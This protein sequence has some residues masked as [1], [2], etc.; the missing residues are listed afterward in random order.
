MTPWV[1]IAQSTLLQAIAYDSA[2]TLLKMQFHDGSVYRYL[3]V[4]AQIYNDLL[5]ADSKGTFFNQR[6][7]GQ[8]PF[9]RG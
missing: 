4:P 5:K 9:A 6:I 8:F 2:A 1:G 3:G 7:R